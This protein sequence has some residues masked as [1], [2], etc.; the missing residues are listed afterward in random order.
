M[1][2]TCI[3]M[4]TKGNVELQFPVVKFIYFLSEYIK[5]QK[6]VN[7][8]RIRVAAATAASLISRAPS[9]RRLTGQKP[10]VCK[11]QLFL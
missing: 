2:Q 7:F 8:F 10:A 4:C 11:Q 5:K 1:R 6:C 9:N 3:S